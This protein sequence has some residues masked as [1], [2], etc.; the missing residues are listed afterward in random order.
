[1]TIKQ[2]QA[3]I[4]WKLE[5][6]I[7][8]CRQVTHFGKYAFGWDILYTPINR[9]TNFEDIM[10]TLCF[11]TIELSERLTRKLGRAPI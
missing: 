2:E 3:E 8:N 1:M 9:R 7:D 10:K 4:Q 6:N 11:R 5:H